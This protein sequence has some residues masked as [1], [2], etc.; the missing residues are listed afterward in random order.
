MNAKPVLIAQVTHG[1]E[2]T[3]ERLIQLL[4]DPTVERVRFAVAYARWEGLG[5]LC[6]SIEALIARGGR[7]ESIYGAGNGVTTP[8]A[9]YYGILLKNLY[10]TRTYAGFVEDKF[11]NATFHPKYYEFRSTSEVR[12]I[13]GSTNLTG[14]GLQRNSEASLEVSCLRGSAE[15]K[16]FDA[17]WNTIKKQATAVGINDVL[18]ISKLP[19]SAAE[20]RSPARLLKSG[21]P[22]LSA[23]A[24]PQPRPL[25][26]KILNLPKQSQGKKDG[27][28]SAFSAISAKPKHLYL[29]ILARETGGQQGK[30]GSAVQLPVATLGAYFGV[31]Q[32]EE[33]AIRLDFPGEQL[34]TNITHF[35]NN[36]HQVRIQPILSITR[37]AILH[38]TRKADNVYDAKFISPAKYETILA[39][40]CVH[41]SRK[42]ARRWGFA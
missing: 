20:D 12:I 25:F 13:V 1:H 22:F 36:T 8:D 16:A 21:K 26:E 29:Q 34:V 39:D 30:P 18:R 11:A 40:R 27:F 10:P 19:G 6:S 17:Y 4:K 23:G 9:L 5:L 32:T 24:K 37:P 31:A 7:I 3:R 42:N 38:L 14:G 2:A 35:S 41:Q 15:E 33:R 28:L